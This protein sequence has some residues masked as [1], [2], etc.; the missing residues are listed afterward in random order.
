MTPYGIFPTTIN[1]VF[2]LFRRVKCSVFGNTD[3]AVVLCPK[4]IFNGIEANKERGVALRMQNGE[5]Y[6]IITNEKYT[7]AE[8]QA[9]LDLTGILQT[10]DYAFGSIQNLVYLLIKTDKSI[11]LTNQVSSFNINSDNKMNLNADGINILTDL[12]TQFGDVITAFTSLATSF[13]ALAAQPALAAIASTLTATQN[14]LT[15][16]SNNIQVLK[17]Q[18]DNVIY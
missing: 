16:T 7:N 9:F 15:N 4:G 8:I 5:M 10:E 3:N 6:N 17:T 18:I 12:S 2:S 11:K 14:V 13:G 1:F